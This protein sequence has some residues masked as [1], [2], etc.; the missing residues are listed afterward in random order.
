MMACC[1]QVAG[2]LHKPQTCSKGY[3]AGA[4]YGGML[5]VGHRQLRGKLIADVM[6]VV[7]M[8]LCVLLFCYRVLQVVQ[9]SFSGLLMCCRCPSKQCTGGIQAGF[10]S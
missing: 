6:Q 1:G 9:C 10:S 7:C 2:V 8:L 5:L 4:D 3:V